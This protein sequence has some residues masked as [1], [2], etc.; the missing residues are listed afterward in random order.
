MVWIE[1]GR[2]AALAGLPQ[3]SISADRTGKG[4]WRQ[5]SSLRQF[6]AKKKES[7]QKVKV[8]S[9]RIRP[10][11]RVAACNT[12]RVF[13]TELTG[14]GLGVLAPQQQGALPAT[15]PGSGPLESEHRDADVPPPPQA[16]GSRV[17]AEAVFLHARHILGGMERGRRRSSRCTWPQGPTSPG[18]PSHRPPQVAAWPSWRPW[19]GPP[20]HPPRPPRHRCC[21]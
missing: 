17:S 19:P 12:G 21:R 5:R 3:V 8:P 9:R 18:C 10:R 14:E 4:R 11:A 2:A 16:R 13:I 6:L 20:H 7:K 15:A 1:A